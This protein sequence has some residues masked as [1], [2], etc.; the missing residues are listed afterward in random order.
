[1]K[2]SLVITS[3]GLD[4][5]VL[6]HY[7]A[8]KLGR[9]NVRALAINYGQRHVKELECASWQAVRLGVPFAVTDLRTLGALLPGSSQT[10]AEVSVPHGHYAA[11]NMKLTVVPNRNM[12]LLAVAIGHAVAHGLEAVAYGAHSGDHAIYPDCRPEFVEAMKAAAKLCDWK[13]VEIY[14]PFS[15]IDKAGIVAIGAQE[16]VDFAHTYSC[17]EGQDVHCGLCGTCVE[18]REAFELAKLPDPTEYRASVQEYKKQLVD[19]RTS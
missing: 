7:Y 4:S 6:L 9:E 1:M 12:I 11:E 17:Y 10:S 3:G 14:A 2:R 18:R 5:T 15:G 13:P 16:G 19:R 8:N